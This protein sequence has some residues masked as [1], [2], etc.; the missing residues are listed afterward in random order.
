MPPTLS[1]MGSFALGAVS[2]P[3]AA[4][5]RDTMWESCGVVRTEDAAAA[6]PG[7]GV[8]LRIP[9]DLDVR[10]SSEGFATWPGAGSSGVVVAPGDLLGA[11]A[12]ARAVAPT[13]GAT[14]RRCHP[15]CC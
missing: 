9:R 10:P 7:L 5:V 11:V 4:G 2:P 1:W 3:A 15:S 12:A 14:S 13:S 8:Q 6:R